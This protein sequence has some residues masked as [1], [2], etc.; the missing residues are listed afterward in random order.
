MPSSQAHSLELPEREVAMTHTI[1]IVESDP[2]SRNQCVAVLTRRGYRVKSYLDRTA[3]LAGIW[4]KPPDLVIVNVSLESE[5][6][7][8]FDLCRQL[9]QIAPDLPVVF[10]TD[11]SS[12]LDRISGLRMNAWDYLITPVSAEVLTERMRWILHT[13]NLTKQH[14]R[15]S[16][17]IHCGA[18]EAD[19]EQQIITWQE[20]SIRM[21]V[22][23]YLL[24]IALVRQPGKLKSYD[25]LMQC[26]RQPLVERNTISS[27]IRRI[28][29]KF[30]EIDPD[31]NSIVTIPGVGY[32]WADRGPHQ[33]DDRPLCQTTP[34]THSIWRPLESRYGRR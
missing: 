34:L 19:P 28:R 11:R 21:T 29:Q 1:A 7:G 13:H 3:A 16:S 32:K 12:D 10:L 25:G 8:G 9:Q 6:E 4:I 15:G 14:K 20:R 23:E 33:S 5:P 26:T 18:L 27:H 17:R 24:T 31:F 30:L 22:T 2:L